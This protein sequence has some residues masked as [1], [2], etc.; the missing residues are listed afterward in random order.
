MKYN[1]GF[2]ETHGKCSTSAGKL[3]KNLKK[4][5]YSEKNTDLI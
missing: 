3:S 2:I 1:L 5:K 4:S